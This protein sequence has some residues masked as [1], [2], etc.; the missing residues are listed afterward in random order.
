MKWLGSLKSYQRERTQEQASYHAVST[1][2]IKKKPG[3]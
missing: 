3:E 1:L 2:P